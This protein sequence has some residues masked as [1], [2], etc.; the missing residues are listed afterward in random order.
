MPAPMCAAPVPVK[1]R[2]A[3]AL[4]AASVLIF[5]PASSAQTIGYTAST[6]GSQGT[7]PDSR[8]TSVYVFNSVDV[9]GGPVRVTFAVP[10]VHQRFVSTGVVVDPIVGTT[11]DVEDRSTGFGDPLVRIDANVLN[12]REHA[13]QIGLAGSVKLPVVDAAGGLGT[14][15]ADVGV[16][17]SVF[18]AVGRTSLFADLLYWKYGDPEGVDFQNSLSYSVGVGRLI[19]NGRWSAMF[20]LAG[21]SNGIDGASAPMQLNATVLALANR[22]QSLAVTAGVGLNDASGDFSIG[23]SWRITR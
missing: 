18:R 13:L 12:D 22:R 15:K 20:A 4:V 14:G 9:T 5:P 2:L 10:F 3:A 21:F 23:A 8:T 16:G 11:G 1:R 7:Y 19:G 17:G 6:Y